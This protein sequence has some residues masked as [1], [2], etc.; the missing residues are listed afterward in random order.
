MFDIV[1]STVGSLLTYEDADGSAINMHP[2]GLHANGE[3]KARLDRDLLSQE[4]V[5]SDGF[6]TAPCVLWANTS[7]LENDCRKGLIGYADLVVNNI[8]ASK[9]EY[10]TIYSADGEALSSSG[11]S[12]GSFIYSDFYHN[13]EINNFTDRRQ[14][15]LGDMYHVQRRLRLSMDVV[16]RKVISVTKLLLSTLD[17]DALRVDQAESLDLGFL[18]TWALAVRSHA[19]SLG[20]ANFFIMGEGDPGAIVD[21]GHWRLMSLMLGRGI[22]QAGT[23]HRNSND[24]SFVF[25]GSVEVA[26]P[27]GLARVPLDNGDNLNPGFDAYIDHAMVDTT[28]WGLTQTYNPCLNDV[29]CTAHNSIP[30]NL[31]AQAEIQDCS[32]GP[33]GCISMPLAHHDLPRFAST[34]PSA[35]KNGYITDRVTLHWKLLAF[36]PGVFTMWQG[37]EQLFE[38]IQNYLAPNFKFD[39]A[40][41]RETMM[42]SAAY[43]K[44]GTATAAEAQGVTTMACPKDSPDSCSDGGSDSFDMTSQGFRLMRRLNILQW[45]LPALHA[46]DDD[47]VMVLQ[48]PEESLGVF[49]YLRRSKG[50]PWEEW[51]MI[52]INTSGE[53]QTLRPSAPDEDLYPTG[54][55]LVNVLASSQGTWQAATITPIA[56]AD[57]PPYGC[58]ML[59]PTKTSSGVLADTLAH[60]EV[61]QTSPKHDDVVLL[62]AGQDSMRI[63]VSI[64]AREPFS[65]PADLP[66]LSVDGSP[67]PASQVRYEIGSFNISFEYWFGEGIHH[68]RAAWP[69]LDIND[70]AFSF[71]ATFRFTVGSAATSPIAH[72]ALHRKP[73]YDPDLLIGNNDGLL[74]KACGAEAVLH[75]KAN[76]ATWFRVTN[77]FPLITTW[78]DWQPY[79]TWSSWTLDLAKTSDGTSLNIV[80]VQY[81]SDGAT[82]Y[83]TYI[84]RQCGDHG[85]STAAGASS[86]AVVRWWPALYVAGTTGS[87]KRFPPW[88]PLG[89][90]LVAKNT[91]EVPSDFLAALQASALERECS[92][93]MFS[94]SP[95]LSDRYTLVLKDP[96]ATGVLRWMGVYGNN[97]PLCQAASDTKPGDI[98]VNDL[99][100]TWISGLSIKH[101]TNTLQWIVDSSEHLGMFIA[102]AAWGPVA[103]LLALVATIVYA[104]CFETDIIVVT[105]AKLNMDDFVIDNGNGGANKST[106]GAEWI[107]GGRSSS[108]STSSAAKV[109]LPSMRAEIL[110]AICSDTDASDDDPPEISPSEDT[111]ASTADVHCDVKPRI[112]FAALEYRLCEVKD[113][114]GQVL[115]AAVKAT[116]G[117]LGKV[118]GIIMSSFPN[119]DCTFL[120]PAYKDFSYPAEAEEASIDVLVEGYIHTIQ[121]WRAAIQQPGWEAARTFYILDSPVF[122]LR[123]CEAIY[124]PD[125]S[126]SDGAY[127]YSLWNQAIAEIMRRYSFDVYHALDFHG[128]LAPLYLLPDAPPMAL[129]LHNAEYQGSYEFPGNDKA[130]LERVRSIF[131][132]PED[133]FGEYIET[134]GS[135]N[136]LHAGVQYICM[137]QGGVGISAVSGHYAERA[138]QKYDIFWRLPKVL[139]RTRLT[140]PARIAQGSW[141]NAIMHLPNPMLESER[142]VL[143]HVP[144]LMQYKAECKAT[145]QGQFGLTV[146]SRARLLVSLGRLVSQKGV[147]ILANSL[148]QMLLEHPSLQ[149]LA[150]GPVGDEY[151]SYA[152]SKMAEVGAKYPSRVHVKAEF[153][154]LP[155]EVFFAADYVAMPS[156]DEPF[157]YVD[158]EFAWKGAITVGT[159]VG[160][161]GK[162]PGVYYSVHNYDQDHMCLQLVRAMAAA[163]KLSSEQMMEMALAATRSCFPL[164]HWQRAMCDMY[165]ACMRAAARVAP[166]NKYRLPSCAFETPC[167]GTA[168]DHDY[169]IAH[170]ERDR[171]TGRGIGISMQ[172]PSFATSPSFDYGD[173]VLG[174]VSALKEDELKR[175]QQGPHGASELIRATSIRALPVG[176]GSVSVQHLKRRAP[177]AVVAF[178]LS[179]AASFCLITVCRTYSG[180][181][182]DSGQPPPFITV[183]DCII[184]AALALL[185]SLAWL[186]CFPARETNQYISGMLDR[187]LHGTSEVFKKHHLL[188]A[189]IAASSAFLVTTCSL[190][191]WVPCSSPGPYIGSTVSE[192]GPSASPGISDGSSSPEAESNG[193]L[194]SFAVFTVSFALGSLCWALASA[195]HKPSS[196]FAMATF[197][198][199]ASAGF[200]AAA[201]GINSL[202]SQV[203]PVAYALVGL[204]TAA[205]PIVPIGLNFMEDVKNLPKHRGRRL[206]LI[207]ALNTLSCTA[208]AI[209]V[210]GLRSAQDCSPDASSG[211][212]SDRFSAMLAAVQTGLVLA[213]CVTGAIGILVTFYLPATLYQQLRLTGFKYQLSRI[214]TRKTFLWGCLSN[215][216]YS[217]VPNGYLFSNSFW[218]VARSGGI[219]PSGAIVALYGIACSGSL[220]LVGRFY[221][222]LTASAPDAWPLFAALLPPPQ[223]LFNTLELFATAGWSTGSVAAIRLAGAMAA[224]FICVL[225]GLAYGFMQL[226]VFHREQWLLATGITILLSAATLGFVQVLAPLV[227]SWAGRGLSEVVPERRAAAH[228]I[229]Y[230]PFELLA[231]VF[232]LLSVYQYK[233]EDLA[234]P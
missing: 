37:D 118:I 70:R 20:K 28:V 69:N 78:S 15:V 16:R 9:A 14:Y 62:H 87:D 103:I 193:S 185:A 115:S 86:E 158:I 104:A 34:F 74:S 93:F 96:Y 41:S 71:N 23:N 180:T 91:W 211:P 138:L 171:S 18:H 224:G 52:I 134:S 182:T 80:T 155:P 188:I 106:A 25:Q 49:K 210:F 215:I 51:V 143:D 65:D 141:P 167:D 226:G 201:M 53:K 127:H 149:F 129:T 137:H 130:E 35:N 177:V 231:W 140:G 219:L 148:E 209:L 85:N 38:G 108:S 122:R 79:T 202:V 29:K 5:G 110:P 123:T 3:A 63:T 133:I 173:N 178:G 156:R 4:A 227:S 117:G 163:S 98:Q 112:L 128:A 197:G 206:G 55:E 187:P 97:I 107:T 152:A 200:L 109:V 186:L 22:K 57:I 159:L 233:R 26:T 162:V 8:F 75:H 95:D 120:I 21:A 135:F 90:D 142:P 39:D 92:S 10:P 154:A 94:S 11:D 111:P 192:N 144:N 61:V 76:G 223:L 165:R 82:P 113:E 66:A 232:A 77:H 105:H 42:S 208:A 54:T 114:E 157:G 68:V 27:T 40:S 48:A 199:A 222:R 84:N 190:L 56:S 43:A 161:L 24:G 119:A 45:A 194:F 32:L 64:L 33:N 102:L 132:I 153:V 166:G 99:D 17:I 81:W 46:R 229:A 72:W 230:A 220:L 234:R 44:Y 217:A 216:L 19:A 116:A 101:E 207:T 139:A 31:A 225:K 189:L 174:N 184:S 126:T 160:G 164:E 228:L 36:L 196:V 124:P 47:E 214:L 168:S 50:S 6:S 131:N 60:P 213:S 170:L 100:Q 175:R 195:W 145:I 59:V 7:S 150:F 181:E 12:F 136:M 121:V 212:G 205:G 172:S 204:S 221:S 151:G 58:L 176:G 183:M 83:Y 146:D 218:L 203:M 13:G 2:F 73:L 125:S 198:M 1:L 88:Q 89:M 169:G 179:F 147:D 30:T 67:I 191:I